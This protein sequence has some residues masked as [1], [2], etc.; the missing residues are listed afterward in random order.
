MAI[1]FRN[2]KRLATSLHPDMKEVPYF[3]FR[4]ADIITSHLNKTRSNSNYD[5]NDDNEVIVLYVI[6]CVS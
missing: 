5:D 3:S 6:Y 4:Q 1:F 2:F